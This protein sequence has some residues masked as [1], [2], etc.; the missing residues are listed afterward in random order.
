[1]WQVRFWVFGQNLAMFW[2]I[3]IDEIIGL[4]FGLGQHDAAARSGKDG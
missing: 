1:M 2:R 3:E 4:L